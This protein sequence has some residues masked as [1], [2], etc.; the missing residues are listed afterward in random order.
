MKIN[1]TITAGFIFLAIGAIFVNSGNWGLATYFV[2][3]ALFYFLYT[4]IV[5]GWK[6]KDIEN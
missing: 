2:G 3:G 4:C 1:I 6:E 5:L